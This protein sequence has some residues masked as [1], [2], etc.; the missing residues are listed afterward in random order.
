MLFQ[1]KSRQGSLGHGISRGIE[2]IE[3]G[4]SRGQFKEKRISRGDQEKIMWNLHGSWFLNL[5]F[6]SEHN[7]CISRCEALFC[8]EFLRVKLQT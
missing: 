7:C 5:E 3:H 4:N 8:S 2:K 1:K 6:P